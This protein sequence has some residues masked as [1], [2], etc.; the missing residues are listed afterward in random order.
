MLVFNKKFL[1]FYKCTHFIICAHVPFSCYTRLVRCD[2]QQYTLLN[3]PCSLYILF[4]H[5][6]DG[7]NIEAREDGEREKKKK[8][9]DIATMTYTAIV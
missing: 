9:N 6:R 8:K 3:L 1:S 5:R 2:L 4:K 7:V